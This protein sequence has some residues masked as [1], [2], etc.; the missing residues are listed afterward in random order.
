MKLN[1]IFFLWLFLV[2]L[3]NFG[4]PGALPIYDVVAAV[5]LSFVSKFLENK[6]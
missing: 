1:K 2:A 6:I 4:F 3:W 5:F